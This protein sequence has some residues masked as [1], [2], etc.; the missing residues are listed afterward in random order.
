MFRGVGPNLVKAWGVGR[1]QGDLRYEGESLD[2]QKCRGGAV[3]GRMPGKRG[4]CWGLCWE[5][6]RFRFFLCCPNKRPPSTAASNPPNSP[7]FP[8]TLP[9]TFCDQGCL[10]PVAGHLDSDDAHHL[11]LLFVQMALQTEKNYFR[12]NYAFHSRYRY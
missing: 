9:S 3:P 7:P 5:Q 1:N 2:P 11:L 4:H 12:I 6:C 10:S 8:S